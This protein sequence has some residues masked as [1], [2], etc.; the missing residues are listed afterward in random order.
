MKISSTCSRESAFIGAMPPGTM[1][2]T[3]TSSQSSLTANVTTGSL[4]VLRRAR[5]VLNDGETQAFSIGKPART[6]KPIP[7]C[8]AGGSPKLVLGIFS[9]SRLRLPS[10][11]VQRPFFSSNNIQRNHGHKASSVRGLFTVDKILC[12]RARVKNFRILT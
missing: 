7:M 12:R 10:F 3:H 5:I 11:H 1:I 2:T 9:N 4:I 6:R 8:L